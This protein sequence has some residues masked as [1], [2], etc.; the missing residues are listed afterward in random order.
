MRRP[1]FTTV[2]MLAAKIARRLGDTA[3][4]NPAST[5][6]WAQDEILQRIR[7]GYND[8]CMTTG[9]MWEM[10]YLDDCP[11]VSNVDQLW[12]REHAAPGT[13]TYSAA[14]FCQQWE[15][16]Y[17][18]Y[19]GIW[20]SN[21]SAYW[22]SDL[23][24]TAYDIISGVVRLPEAMYDIERATWDY[25][26]IPPIR[27]SKVSLMDKEYETLEGPVVAYIMDK[28]GLRSFR[29]YKVPARKVSVYPI[30]NS[31]FGI[32]RQGS[33]YIPDPPA[34]PAVLRMHLDEF[35]RVFGGFLD[36]PPSLFWDFSPGA[37]HT[38]P[39]A[40]D[41]VTGWNQI[42]EFANS[43][44][45]GSF[46]LLR[47]LTG[48][49]PS[50]GPFG[51]ARRMSQGRSNTKIEHRRRGLE[52]RLLDMDSR[53]E[54]PTIYTRYLMFYAL[55]KLYGRKGPGQD[56]KLSKHFQ[57]RYLVGMTRIET[58]RRRVEQIRLLRMG[59]GENHRT[60]PPLAQPPAMMTRNWSGWRR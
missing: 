42:P 9:C 24:F 56:L 52:A 1:E 19:P 36:A 29:K 14:N 34:P 8:F 47:I 13:I 25:M 44:I 58:R 17:S 26:R 41:K 38:L 32:L 4:D 55:W 60:R 43:S 59:G 49:H 30:I 21:H 45:S 7:Q 31:P 28:D 27:S 10:E 51:F 3:E 57:A 35:G 48:Y 20:A 50:Y 39:P 5:R 2:R 46:G 11:N 54:L 40:L 12:E 53:I 6:I 22:E 15:R 33:S 37:L 16:S 23:G 18:L